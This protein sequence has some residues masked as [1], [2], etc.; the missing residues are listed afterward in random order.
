M[1]A[2]PDRKTVSRPRNVG[3]RS[4]TLT[5]EKSRR[6]RGPSSMSSSSQDVSLGRA[7]ESGRRSDDRRPD[8]TTQGP[9]VKDKAVR[10][11]RSEVHAS[12]TSSYATLI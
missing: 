12:G 7:L 11:D 10:G 9:P 1:S 8:Y 2:F 3:E 4:Q 5:P 6:E